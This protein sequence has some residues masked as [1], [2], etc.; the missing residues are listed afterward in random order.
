[1][2]KW[3]GLPLGILFTLTCSVVAQSQGSSEATKPGV[4]PPAQIS[5]KG[6][7]TV[8]G[9]RS[10]AIRETGGGL[11]QVIESPQTRVTGLRTTFVQIGVSDIVRVEG[12]VPSDSHVMTAH[13]VEVLFAVAGT[14]RAAQKPANWLWRLIQNGGVTVDLP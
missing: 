5:T 14:E 8:K 7:V 1:M 10:I 11:L 12:S 2:S 13:S 6:I 9:D 4:S 3:H